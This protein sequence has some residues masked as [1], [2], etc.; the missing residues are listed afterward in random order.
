MHDIALEWAF[1]GFFHFKRNQAIQ[2]MLLVGLVDRARRAI[3]HT[4]SQELLQKCC[5]RGLAG[6]IEKGRQA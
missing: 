2:S 6:D 1:R 3:T 5:S 4:V